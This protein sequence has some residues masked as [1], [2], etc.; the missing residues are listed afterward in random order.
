MNI[1]DHPLG[2]TC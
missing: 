1:V 2:E